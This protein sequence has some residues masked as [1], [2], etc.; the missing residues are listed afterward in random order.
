MELLFLVSL[1]SRRTEILEYCFVC[2]S[3]PESYC[4]LL[5]QSLFACHL[6]T[7]HS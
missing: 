2:W 7:C 6:F 4:F 1:V 3:A 5:Y